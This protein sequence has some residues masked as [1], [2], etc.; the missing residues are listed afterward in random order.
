MPLLKQSF[1][2]YCEICKFL[3]KLFQHNF[4]HGVVGVADPLELKLGTDGI[5]TTDASTHTLQLISGLTQFVQSD[6]L[7]NVLCYTKNRNTCL[8]QDVAYSCFKRAQIRGFQDRWLNNY[9]M[10]VECVNIC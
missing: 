8:D 5:Y 9:D 1:D 10:K 4:S 7:S 2:F 6:D 3:K